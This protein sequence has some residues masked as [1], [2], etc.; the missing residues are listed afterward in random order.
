MVR[1]A[2]QGSRY[3][4]FFSDMKYG[5]KKNALAAAVA[6]YD[7]WSLE[8]P[9]RLSAKDRLTSRNQTGRVGVYLAV[10]RDSVGEAH[11]SFCASWTDTEGRRHKINFS[12]QRYGKKRAWQLACL[13]RETM[14]I[15]RMHLLRQLEKQSAEK[16][17]QKNK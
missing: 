2:R 9:E 13:A 4:K 15:N 6:Q 11:E 5:G 17:S 8:L 7:V 14:K 16:K 3:Q 12:L 1:I 10:S